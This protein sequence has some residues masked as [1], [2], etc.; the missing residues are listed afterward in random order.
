VN[1]GASAVFFSF[2]AIAGVAPLA[3]HIV[4]GTPET[5][6]VVDPAAEVARRDAGAG[7]R[8]IAWRVPAKGD[9]T[10]GCFNNWTR[11]RPSDCGCSLSREQHSWG[12]SDSFPP[13]SG[14]MEIYARVEGGRVTSL[15]LASE[16]CAVAMDG[17][18]VAIL[19]GA[20]AARGVALLADIARK[21]TSGKGEDLAEKA[22]AAIAHHSAREVPAAIQ[23]IVAISR[24]ATDPDQRAHALFWLSQTDEPRAA[25][26]IREAIARDPDAEVREQ[27]VFALSQLDDATDQLMA[28]LRESRDQRVKRQ[29]L[30][31]LGQSDDPRALA[32]IER[33]L[34]Q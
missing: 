10:V 8:W 16:S 5:R 25:A 12:S 19:D 4:G 13:E 7:R 9:R 24:E 28:V 11:N 20:D 30:F 1:A 21:P 27:G 15:L 31:W 32:E 17:E 6:S 2:A 29:A 14:E 3:A 22:L 33:V 26:L 18:R 23:A 34:L